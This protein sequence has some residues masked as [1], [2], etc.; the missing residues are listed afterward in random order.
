MSAALGEVSNRPA[1]R[2]LKA[3]NMGVGIGSLTVNDWRRLT[4]KAGFNANLEA[5]IA[6]WADRYLS[7]NWGGPDEDGRVHQ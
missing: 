1:A 2:H 6:M 3:S 7:I 4:I 5:S